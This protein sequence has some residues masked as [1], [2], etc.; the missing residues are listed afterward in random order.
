MLKRRFS[1]L[2]LLPV[3]CA[4]A[5]ATAVGCGG[6]APPPKPVEEAPDE[7]WVTDEEREA[8]EAK[9]AAAAALAEE[10][11]GPSRPSLKLRDPKVIETSVDYTGAVLIVGEA[12]LVFPEDAVAKGTVVHFGVGGQKGPSR[13]GLT[14]EFT[15]AMRSIGAPFILE[16]PLPKGTERANFALSRTETTDGN[17]KLVWDVVAATRIDTERGLAVLELRELRDGWMHLTSDAPK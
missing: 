17:E 15:P 14:Y 10:D 11:T 5:L 12:E 16:L 2:T 4:V 1:H 8:Q 7:S 3:S 9:A 6:A 13:V